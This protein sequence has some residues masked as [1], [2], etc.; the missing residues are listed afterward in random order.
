MDRRQFTARF[1]AAAAGAALYQ[2]PSYAAA[3]LSAGQ[4]PGSVPD[5]FL[6]KAR[7]PDGFLWGTATASYQVEG[8]WNE[9]G[10][11]ESVWDRFTHTP[12]KVRGGVTGG[13]C[14]RSVPPI[15]ARHRIGQTP[16]P[17]EPA[18]F[19]LL[20][21]HSACRNRRPEHEGAGS[22]QP[23]G[24]DVAGGRHPALVHDVSLG[25]STGAGRSWRL[26]KPRSSQLLRR[27]CRNSRQASRR[28]NH[29]L[30]AL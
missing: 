30:G 29:S 13:R 23:L 20:A 4:I 27:L 26:A 28:S 19:H 14:L 8:A 12:G 6:Q 25:S 11:G 17:E 10:K 5:S 2:R 24:R 16:Q 3:P 22:L 18:F 15:S 7:F 21:A 9:D 1:L